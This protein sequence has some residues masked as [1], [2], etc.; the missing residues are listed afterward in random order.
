MRT[1]NNVRCT[2]VA[3]E[4]TNMTTFIL[5]VETRYDFHSNLIAV[6]AEDV[7]DARETAMQYMLLV[8]RLDSRN[9][10]ISKCELIATCENFHCVGS[11][12]KL[13]RTFL[14]DIIVLA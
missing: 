5:Q 9:L 7:N 1:S 12:G 11:D 10:R 4:F 8:H 13:D 14:G 3:P 2:I 6:T